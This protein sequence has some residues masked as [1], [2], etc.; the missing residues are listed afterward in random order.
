[1][2]GARDVEAEAG[3][4]LERPAACRAER[5]MG[6]ASFSTGMPI[7]SSWFTTARP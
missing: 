7:M 1:M 3:E 2:R 5:A 6:M 4:E